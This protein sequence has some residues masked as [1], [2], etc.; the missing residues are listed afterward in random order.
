MM[1]SEDAAYRDHLQL[2]E[3]A[4]EAEARRDRR[5]GERRSPGAL[6][7]VPRSRRR[8]RRPRRSAPTSCASARRRSPS[9]DG[10]NPFDTTIAQPLL[11]LMGIVG[12]RADAG[13][14]ELSGLLLARAAARQREIS[15]RLA[16]GAGRGR[17]VRQF[18][19]ESLVLAALGG[20]LGLVMAAWF[21]ARLLTLFV[22]GR[23]RRAVGGARLA[24]ARVHGRR[25]SLLACVRRR[26][27][28]GAAGG[29]RQ[30]EPRAEG[31]RARRAT[32]ASARASSSRS[33][34]SRWS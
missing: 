1:M 33:S 24:R 20:G 32:A 17:L 13:L 15:I 9:P 2:A 10:F 28:A 4:G 21:S 25:S 7:V 12:T 11:I 6:D 34:R 27:R 19:T 14:R 3:P 30:R 23:E 5:A 26:S 22:N 8:L 18:L 29:P 16:I 31:R